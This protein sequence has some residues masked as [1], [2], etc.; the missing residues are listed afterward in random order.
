[1]THISGRGELMFGGTNPDHYEG[2]LIE[3]PLSSV[4]SGYW[5][6]RIEDIVNSQSLS[7]FTKPSWPGIV[8]SGTSI[9][10]GPYLEVSIILQ[11]Y[12]CE[13]IY[14]DE[15]EQ[16]YNDIDCI[17]GGASNQLDF[18]LLECP[19]GTTTVDP[20]FFKIHGEYF[21]IQSSELVI[22][23]EDTGFCILAFT[24]HSWPKWILGDPFLTSFYS[25]YDYTHHKIYFARSSAKRI[26][27]PC[28]TNF[29]GNVPTPHPNSL[30]SAKPTS[31]PILPTARPNTFPTPAP[32]L[33][34]TQRSSSSPKEDTSSVAKEDVD[35]SGPSSLPEPP[36]NSPLDAYQ[37]PSVEKTPKHS[38]AESVALILGYIS[39][40]LLA[41]ILI[42]GL[43]FIFIRRSNRFRPQ[44]L[45][46]EDAPSTEMSRI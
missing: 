7:Y 26:S 20:L 41:I 14:W 2:C 25:V 32:T 36:Q 37:Q 45:V 39:E 13:C 38:A 3:V 46:D 43:A 31:A 28:P 19:A 4:L 11:Q 29:L 15:E 16:G 18:G 35:G 9:I 12:G 23:I 5:E 30:P 8:D 33:A 42:V 17:E 44:R 22:P 21:E 6:L 40:V 27:A 10:I 24:T 1:M 34:S